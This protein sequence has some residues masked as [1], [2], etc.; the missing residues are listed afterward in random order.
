M[1]SAEKNALE[2]FAVQRLLTHESVCI[3]TAELRR[4]GCDVGLLLEMVATYNHLPLAD[5]A[6][7]FEKDFVSVGREEDFGLLIRRRLVAVPA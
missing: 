7:V 6:F 5:R 3:Q 2:N 4:Q 1:N